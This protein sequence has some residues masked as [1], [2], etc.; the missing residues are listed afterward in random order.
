MGGTFQDERISF[1][2]FEITV[3]NFLDQGAQVENR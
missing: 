2:Q 1:Q 3:G